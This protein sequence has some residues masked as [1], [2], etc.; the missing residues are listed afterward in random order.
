[1]RNENQ[2]RVVRTT[3][4][5]I[6]SIQYSTWVSFFIRENMSEFLTLSVAEN[7]LNELNKNIV[8]IK[9]KIQ[10]SEGQ[11]KA[12]FEEYDAKKRENAQKIVDLKKEIKE[13]YVKYAGAKI[14][15]EAMKRAALLSHDFIACSK[16]RNLEE[17]IAT[18][19]E[20]NIRLRKKLDLIKYEREKQEQT[21]NV[22]QTER[23]ELARRRG[24]CVF[25]RKT[26]KP[27]KRKIEGLEVRLEHIRMMQIKANISRMKYRSISSKL[28]EK[29]VFY[30]SSLKDLEDGIRQQENEI[31]RLQG[32]KEEAIELRDNTQETLVK[33][34]I[35]ETNSSKKR[36]FIIKE[37][38]ADQFNFIE[39]SRS[40]SMSLTY[41]I[42]NTTLSNFQK[43]LAVARC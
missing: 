26:E 8:E 9:K 42:K 5:I 29:S 20:N 33:E 16:K 11:R 30:A 25:K 10:L 2:N 15:K 39:L 6:R 31:K 12:N 14:N 37:Y 36:D 17:I 1:M 43:V 35:E 41:V 3:N 24:H 38:R 19:S 40:I 32:V 27:M 23:K 13:L 4:N 34:E 7:K 18:A 21:L 28:K 22:L